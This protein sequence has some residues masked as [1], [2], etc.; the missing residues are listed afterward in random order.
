MAFLHTI[1]CLGF[2]NQICASEVYYKLNAFF[3]PF[4]C[5]SPE[6]SYSQDVGFHQQSCVEFVCFSQ[7]TALPFNPLTR[8]SSHPPTVRIVKPTLFT[9]RRS[10]SG[11]E[12][13]RIAS[14]SIEE[15]E[16]GAD[17]VTK[18]KVK[19]MKK[20]S[21]FSLFIDNV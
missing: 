13:I 20:E 4:W 16:D 12:N 11:L 17:L 1:P 19:L 6:V 10:V 15:E 8:I 18:I 14:T 21:I 9:I 2:V 3:S 7:L 5:F